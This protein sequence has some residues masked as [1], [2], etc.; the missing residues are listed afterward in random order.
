MCLLKDSNA[1]RGEWRMCLVHS[2]SPDESGK[3]RNVEV[4]VKPNQGGSKDYV[5][6]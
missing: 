3:V 4:L 6:I 2:V 5:P 1:Y